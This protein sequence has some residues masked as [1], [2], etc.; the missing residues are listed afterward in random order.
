[1]KQ[2]SLVVLLGLLT[3][4]GGLSGT[5]QVDLS[6]IK[7]LDQASQEAMLTAVNGARANGRNCFKPNGADVE[8]FPASSAL[9]LNSK[10]TLAAQF[11]AQDMAQNN[12]MD[13]KG[14][15]GDTTLNRIQ[16]SGYAF[17]EVGE[18]LAQVTA[19]D[20]LGLQ[21]TIDESIK[22]WL[23]SKTGH[24]QTLMGGQYSELG[25]GFASAV[26]SG[27][28]VYYWVQVFGKPQK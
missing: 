18:N 21:T 6:G 22:E 28:H 19:V 20:A 7:V 1:M 16:A 26:V 3:A 15:R 24:C 23:I 9:T 13:H 14:S 25:V 10:L 11:H 17:L 27:K 8:F 5:G 12:F 2:F 4:C